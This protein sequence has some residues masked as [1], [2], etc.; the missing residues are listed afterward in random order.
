MK[1]ESNSPEP[2]DAGDLALPASDEEQLADVIH[3]LRT[4]PQALAQV[5]SQM[6]PDD[7]R[8]DGW[9]PFARRLFLQVLGETGRVS[10]ACEYAQLS[11]QSAYALRARDPVFAAGWDAAC[12]IA[13]A[14]LADALYE[15]AV[16]G[17][18]DTITRGGEVVVDRHRH[19]SRLS[20]AVLHRLDKRC[21]RA[22]EAGARHLAL[23]ARWDDWLRLVGKGEDEAAQALLETP[24]LENPLLENPPHGQLGQLPEGE[25]PTED[26]EEDKKAG[27]DLSDRC[28]THPD[29]LWLTSFPPPAGFIGY[30]NRPYDEDQDVEPYERECTA[31]ETAILDADTARAAAA[32]RAEHEALRDSWFELLSEDLAVWRAASV[33]LPT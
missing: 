17:V 14:P 26:D 19:D 27:L 25:N 20:I 8:R 21:D 4:D 1:H 29:K 18:T 6:C 31:Q 30:E 11:K 7:V 32:E 2:D 3:L 5:V 16:E 28:W 15:R 23:V 12:E 9:T 13:R 24:L 33:G 22:A 10:R